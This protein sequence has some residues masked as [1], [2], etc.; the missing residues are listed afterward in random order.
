MFTIAACEPDYNRPRLGLSETPDEHKSFNIIALD[1]G[2]YAA[3]PNNR[4]LWYEASMIPKETL[5]PDFK[6]STKDFAV[7]TDPSWSVGASTEWQYK[8]PEEEQAL[9]TKNDL[10]LIFTTKPDGED[11]S[12]CDI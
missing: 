10:P 3:Q 4:V 5:T 9:K 7:E 2:Q 8:T 12:Q 1:N 6:V 11:T